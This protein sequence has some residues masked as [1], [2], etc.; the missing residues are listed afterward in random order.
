MGHGF[1]DQG[2]NYDATGA[3]RDWWTADDAADYKKRAQMVVDQYNALEVLPGLKVNGELTLGENLADMTGLIIS[4]RAYELALGGKPAPTL[5][6]LSGPQ[7]FFMGWAQVWR[8]KMR[9]DSLRQQ[10]MT[11][12]HAPAQFRGNIPL[13]N[14]PAFYAA[15]EVKEGDKL[16]LPADQ[17]ARIW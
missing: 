9:D 1:D 4:Y 11:D 6:G 2:R 5:D 12:P 17:R 16:F 8:T 14:T 13:R 15:F 3:L 7:R 10:V